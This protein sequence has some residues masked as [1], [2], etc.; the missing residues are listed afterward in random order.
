MIQR[1]QTLWLLLSAICCVFSFSQPFYSGTI[2]VNNIVTADEVHAGSNFFLAVLTGAS[3]LL[4]IC[5]I[6]LFK[7]RKLQ[8]RLCFAGIGIS[9][10]I[11]VIY[12]A[13]MKKFENGNI[14]LWC[15]FAFANFIGYVMAA[16]GVWKDEKLV[17][18][19]DK[20]R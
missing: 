4:A 16:S 9:L 7:N 13:E 20:L 1:Q 8:L 10:L 14:T 12:F 3:L 18:S 2:R 11:L 5:T 19:L 15:L 17:K 6:F